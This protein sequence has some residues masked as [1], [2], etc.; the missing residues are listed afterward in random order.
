MH[1][2]VVE[3]LAR[4]AVRMRPAVALPG[5]PVR[6]ASAVIGVPQGPRGQATPLI[7]LDQHIAL[8]PGFD[9]GSCGQPWPCAPAKVRLAEEY[10]KDKLSLRLYLNLMCFEAI[11]EAIKDHDW[12]KVDD[13]YERFVGWAEVL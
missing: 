10:V 13:L 6:R 2:S 9:C 4:I 12:K 8:R 11:S 3:V 7:S 1:D 5:G